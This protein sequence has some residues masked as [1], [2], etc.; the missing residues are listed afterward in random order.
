MEASIIFRSPGIKAFL[1][2]FFFF[3]NVFEFPKQVSHLFLF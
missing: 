2:V 1:Y 3:L